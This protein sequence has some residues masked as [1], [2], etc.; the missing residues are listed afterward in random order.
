MRGCA[1]QPSPPSAPPL[2]VKLV[3]AAKSRYASSNLPEVYAELLVLLRLR[4]EALATRLFD[5]GFD[6]SQYAA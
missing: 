2:A 1:L 4:G 3:A 6:G 5:Y